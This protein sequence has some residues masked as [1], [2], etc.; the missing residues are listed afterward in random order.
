MNLHLREFT[1]RKRTKKH[2]SSIKS[3]NYQTNKNET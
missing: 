3:D 2:Q 1:Y